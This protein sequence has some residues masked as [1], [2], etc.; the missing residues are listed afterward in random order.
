MEKPVISAENDTSAPDPAG[1]AAALSD[2]LTSDSFAN[3]DRLRN[4]LEYV[5]TE[6]IDGRGNGI[7]GKTIAQDVYGRNAAT[8]GD[9]ENVVRVDA[10]RLRRRLADYYSSEGKDADVRIY[11]DSGGYTP[12]FEK[13]SGVRNISSNPGPTSGPEQ[14][15]VVPVKHHR[16]IVGAIVLFF[17]A[18][19]IADYYLRHNTDETIP[20]TIDEADASRVLQR[21]ALLEKSP[22]SLQAVN[23]VEQARGL[24]IPIFDPARQKLS[25][26]FF[27]QA[28][29]VDPSYYGS[30]AGA[31]EA[32]AS[33]AL[34]SPEGPGKQQLLADSQKMSDMAIKLAPTDPWVQ[35]ASSWTA[36][37]LKD[38]D[39]AIRLSERARALA[40]RDG[41]ILDT[42]AA[43]AIF[44]GEFEKVLKV[45]DP[46]T[47]AP[48]SARRFGNRNSYAGANFFLG[49]HEEALATLTDAAELGDPVSPVLAS[50][51]VAATHALGNQ[52][53][54]RKLASDLKKS[55]PDAPIDR[56]LLSFFRDPEHAN[57]L[58]WRLKDAGW[59]PGPAQAETAP[60]TPK[61]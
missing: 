26:G 25:L 18:A 30:Y 8:D 44:T 43:I 24:L 57:A 36:F 55:W 48:N 60:D 50:L 34:L 17:M 35:S 10:R 39:K 40:P 9:P 59:A 41:H 20:L 53:E 32:T 6:A 11:I 14:G 1:I 3:A 37:A 29:E 4:F 22:A 16:M 33:L 46:K 23:M 31:A 7:R 27:R 15:A 52:E 49:N 13:T 19:A 56:V 54:A 58:I 42:Y 45:S 28:I 38:Y 51:R 5:V 47:R 21:Q 2:I 12:R 61:N